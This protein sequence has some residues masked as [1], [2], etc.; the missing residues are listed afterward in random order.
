M[1]ANDDAGVGLGND[2]YFLAAGGEKVVIQIAVARNLKRQVGRRK[3]L[4]HGDAHDRPR[5]AIGTIGQRFASLIV[6]P[7]MIVSG[8]ALFPFG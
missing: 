3:L 8:M 4:R 5:G 6:G 2:R 1:L 7:S